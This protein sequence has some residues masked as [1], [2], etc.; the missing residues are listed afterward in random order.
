MVE[1]VAN[2]LAVNGDNTSRLAC[3]ATSLRLIIAKR[4]KYHTEAA[5]GDLKMTALDISIPIQVSNGPARKSQGRLHLTMLLHCMARVAGKSATWER[6]QTV[7]LRPV[8]SGLP[9]STP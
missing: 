8:E 9:K 3:V 6:S 1:L 5:W 7:F 4:A 2:T